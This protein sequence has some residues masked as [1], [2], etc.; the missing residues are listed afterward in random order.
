MIYFAEL[1]MT[2]GQHAAFNGAMLQVLAR[3]FPREK[4]SLFA[5]QNHYKE[6]IAKE[7]DL[8]EILYHPVHVISNKSGDP[9]RWLLKF[10]NEFIQI[11]RVLIRGRKKSIH[12]IYFAFLSPLGQWLVSKYARYM[13]YKGQQILIT[14]HGLDILHPAGSQKRV[15][16]IYAKL[17][18]KAFACAA[19]NK[20]YIV[21]EERVAD[22]LVEKK[23]L[24]SD[25]VVRISHP[26]RFDKPVLM[27]ADK[28]ITFA[29]LGVARLAKNSHLFFDLASR[30]A[31]QIES[32]D[33]LF[34]VIGPVLP[35]LKPHLNPWVQYIN[36]EVFLSQ[37]D[38]QRHCERAHY[39]VFFYDETNYAL[40][41]SGAV[42]DA[43]A[44]RLPILALNSPVFD[45]LQSITSSFP[46]KLY[47]DVE[48]MYQGICEIIK[49]HRAIHR[50]FDAAFVDLQLHYSIEH[51]A[52]QLMKQVPIR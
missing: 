2:G 23:Y 46:G 4:I 47:P 36:H 6:L 13:A 34:Q 43:I 48:L 17:L 24:T 12:L 7:S 26:Y 40:T 27:R 29:H 16:R 45:S 18:K 10:L 11:I 5:A 42:M 32:G 39:A 15:D 1:F 38:Y 3:A 9:G 25:E 21:L 37:A 8:S 31:A 30:F 51:V 35:E 44:Y 41:S 19:K 49:N 20:R 28:P 33:L 22:Y 14:L 50:H 52:E